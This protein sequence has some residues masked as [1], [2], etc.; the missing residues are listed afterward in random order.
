MTPRLRFGKVH[1]FN[2]LID[3]WQSGASTSTM[4]GELASEANVFVAA[5]DKRAITVKAGGD[6]TD[7]RARSTGDLLQNGATVEENDPN[8][9]F[10]PDYPYA[11]ATADAQ[12]Q[13]S[14]VAGAGAVPK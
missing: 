13:A 4:A 1:L 7:G 3:R 9:V 8:L 14:I 2:N 6:P 11:P 10:M 12:L 5:D